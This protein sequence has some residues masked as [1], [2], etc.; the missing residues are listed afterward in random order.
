MHS[1]LSTPTIHAAAAS[2]RSSTSSATRFTH[3]LTRPLLAG[4]PLLFAAAVVGT[5]AVAWINRNEGHLTAET[6]A[7]YWL[8]II[9]GSM[10]L[11]LMIYPLRKRFRFLHGLGR[12]AHWFRLHMVL[13]I[14]G[15]TLVVL[16]TNFKLGSL[17]SQLALLT[18]LVVVAS[19][20]IGRYL[21]AQVHRGLYGRHAELRDLIADSREIAGTIGIE[22]GHSKTI[23]DMLAAFE[24]AVTQPA[25]HLRASIWRAVTLPI[26]SRRARREIARQV[27]REIRATSR[28]QRWGW[29]ERRRRSREAEARL[30]VYFAAVGKAARLAAFERLLA[31]WHVLHFPLFLMLILTATLHIVAVHLY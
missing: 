24:T 13:G 15:P 1:Q 31:M 27:A 12:V 29:R 16:H 7:G 25:P 8:G 28:R 4:A 9:G 6:G 30:A 3:Y 11:L 23:T 26:R 20:I 18:M 5:L 14:A 19:G 10:M 22:A 21:Y 2:A 17:N